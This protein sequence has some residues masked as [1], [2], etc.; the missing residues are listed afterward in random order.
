MV[1]YFVRHGGMHFGLGSSGQR[2]RDRGVASREPEN[3]GQTPGNEPEDRCQIE[4]AQLVADRPTGP[5]QPAS[6]VL[7]IKGG[8]DRHR[9]VEHTRARRLPDELQATIPHLTRLHRY[10]SGTASR[11]CRRS[12]TEGA[13]KRKF[14]A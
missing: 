10:R 8:T 5:K 3:S 4:E 13:P 9:F 14:K 2:P 11:A 12:R 1:H 7:R 6:T